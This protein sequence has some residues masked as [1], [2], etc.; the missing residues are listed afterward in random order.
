MR[1]FFVEQILVQ[2][3]PL[4][5]GVVVTKEILKFDRPGVY[6]SDEILVS[7]QTVD[8]PF[9]GGEVLGVVR[10]LQ[11]YQATLPVL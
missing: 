2:L 4:K 3:G 11:V 5:V 7:L 10:L 1:E 9:D 6:L 8:H